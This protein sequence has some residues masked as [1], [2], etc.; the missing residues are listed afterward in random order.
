M[1]RKCRFC[2]SMKHADEVR[3]THAERTCF[4]GERCSDL[5]GAWYNQLGSELLV[6]H[7]QDGVFSGEYRTA[8]ERE[9]GAAGDSFS[10]VT[11]DHPCTRA[12]SKSA[13]WALADPGTP[14]SLTAKHKRF[15]MFCLFGRGDFRMLPPRTLQPRP[16]RQS[17]RLAK[18]QIHDLCA[19]SGIG[20][21]RQ[22]CFP[23]FLNKR[24]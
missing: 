5:Q 22:F 3:V 8:V 20:F 17:T 9:P 4:L 14:A 1:S 13:S 7:T 24:C 16:K 2:V 6:N 21:V 19:D 12:K 15:N 18:I 23:R 10:L 11:G